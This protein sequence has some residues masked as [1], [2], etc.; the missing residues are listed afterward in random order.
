MSWSEN[1]A[2]AR[3]L[4]EEMSILKGS[5]NRLGTQFGTFDSEDGLVY[6]IEELKV[7]F[8]FLDLFK[9]F[10]SD[11][12]PSVHSQFQK[13]VELRNYLNIY[14]RHK[15]KITKILSTTNSVCFFLNTDGFSCLFTVA[16]D[17]IPF[18]AKY[19]GKF[20]IEFIP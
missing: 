11:L 7:S 14:R 2:V 5:L 18:Y 3:Q 1:A 6:A 8:F 19:S 10:I 16:V 17:C 20:K 12:Q 13:K 4:Q 9:V 15:P